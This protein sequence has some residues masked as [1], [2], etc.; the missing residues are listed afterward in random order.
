MNFKRLRQMKPSKKPL[1]KFLRFSSVGIQMG[2]IITL[3]S[4]GGVKADEA[5]GT[6]PWMTVVGSLSATVIAIYIVIKE[7]NNLSE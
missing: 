6:N 1:N 7:V 4:L 5:W 3:G 2:V